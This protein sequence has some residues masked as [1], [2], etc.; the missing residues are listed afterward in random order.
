M[1]VIVAGCGRVGSRLAEYLSFERHDVVVIDKESASFRRLGGTFNGIT[2]EGMAFDEEVLREAGAEHADAFAAVT[3]EDNTNLMAAEVAKVVFDVPSVLSRLYNPEKELTY[4]KLD[5]DYVCGTTLITQRIHEQLFQSENSVV[6]QDRADLGIQVVELSVGDE[7]AGKPAG[8][9]NYGVSSKLLML[10]RENKRLHFDEATP[11]DSG[12]RVVMLLRREGRSTVT[13]CLGSGV[14]SAA[15]RMYTIPDELAAAAAAASPAEGVKV[16][17]GGCSMV[18]AHLAYIL[19][20]E[21][22]DVTIIDED[23]ALFKRLPPGYTG[24]FVEGVIY[25]EEALLTAGVEQAGA[26]VAVTKK[27]NKNLMAAEVA[28]HIFGVPHVMARLFNPD[29]EPTY[30]ALRMPFVSG[31]TVLAQVLLERL[32][33]PVISVKAA[34][35]FNKYNLVEFESPASWDGKTVRWAVDASGVTFAYIVRRSSAYMPDDNLVL[36]S[37]DTICALVTTKRLTRLEK[38]LSKR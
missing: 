27:D 6:Q 34:C 7:A 30:Q 10:T 16:I 33:N 13:E 32:L 15:C 5:V 17:V 24:E 8:S 35:L 20:M 38:S 23:P 28:R 4:F 36:R 37:G 9:L 26:F 25:D 19:S 14:D 2:L 11:L 3:N 31:T 1:H 12:D 21:G 22:H 18:G 29:K